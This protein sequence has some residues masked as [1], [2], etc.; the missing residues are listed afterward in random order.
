MPIFKDFLIII[1]NLPLGSVITTIYPRVKSGSVHLAASWPVPGL[2]FN[3]IIFA[4]L[5]RISFSFN[6]HFLTSEG[7]PVFICLL[8]IYVLL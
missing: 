6:L 1:A 8:A 3:Y 7:E 2:T 4:N 5:P